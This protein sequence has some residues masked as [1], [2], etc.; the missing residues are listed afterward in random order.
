MIGPVLQAGAWP[1]MTGVTGA[2]VLVGGCAAAF[3]AAD[4]LLL[5]VCFTLLAAATAF[6][7]D[8]PASQ[9]VDVTPT[10]AAR[11]TGIRALGLLP[12]LAAGGLTMLATALR[13]AD[14]PWAAVGLA[15]LGYVLVGFTAACLARTRTGEPGAIAGTV[16]VLALTTAGVVPRLPDW[17]RTFPTSGGQAVS[18]AVLWSTALAVCT[19]L[20]L[21]SVMERRPVRRGGAR[22][23]ATP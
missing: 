23:P 5:P 11:R 8:E 16:I 3:P 15:L 18:T 20:I 17:L 14:L 19:V 6:A 12:S 2:A 21:G 9:V 10:S 1:T 7:L 22:D 4:V 13:G